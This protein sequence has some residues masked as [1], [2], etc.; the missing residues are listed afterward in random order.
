MIQILRRNNMERQELNEKAT[1]LW[2]QVGRLVDQKFGFNNHLI[3]GRPLEN[4]SNH[5]SD[6]QILSF[7][8]YLENQI[9]LL[10]EI[11]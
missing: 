5:P 6:Q 10:N 1:K 2:M 4:A 3:D 7:I 9:S 11:E 8:V